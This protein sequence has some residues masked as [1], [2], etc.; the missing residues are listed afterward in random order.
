MDSNKIME[1]YT[2]KAEN[3]VSIGF[4]LLRLNQFF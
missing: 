1:I 2:V 4:N 3:R